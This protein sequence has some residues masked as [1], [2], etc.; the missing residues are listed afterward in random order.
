MY[1]HLEVGD[2]V[3]AVH[4]PLDG[5]CDP[6]NIA[7]A[8]AKGARMRGAQIFEH[9]KVVGVTK[10]NG[11]V[12]GVDYL[13]GGAPGQIAA[14]VVVNCAGMWGAR[15]GGGVRRHAAA[16]R[17]RAFLLDHRADPRSWPSAGAAGAG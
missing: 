13:A 10:A 5:Q 7:M 17:L 8:L 1:P 4:L 16:A 9:V 6:A 14:D 11:K 2:V 15:A 12:T 3:G